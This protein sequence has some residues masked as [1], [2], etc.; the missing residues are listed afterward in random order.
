MLV[1]CR[2]NPKGGGELIFSS[3]FFFSALRCAR[4]P[5]VYFILVLILKTC[6]VTRR[7]HL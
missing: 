5:V 4:V 7:S 2:A 1:C 3:N 6:Y